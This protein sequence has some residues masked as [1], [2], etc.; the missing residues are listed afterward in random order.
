MPIKFFIFLFFL[1][2]FPKA[3]GKEKEDLV[4]SYHVG[5]GAA[6]Y[7]DLEDRGRAEVSIYVASVEKNNLDIEVYMVHQGVEL[8]EMWQFFELRLNDQKKIDLKRG[9]VWIKD[10]SS[11]E[12]IPDDVMKGDDDIL[13]SDFLITKEEDLVKYK[14]GKELLTIGKSKIETVHYQK[15]YSDKNIDFY[16]AS[17]VKPFGLVKLISKSTKNNPEKNYV[18]HLKNLIKGVKAKIDPTTAKPLSARVK[19]LLNL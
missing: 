6:Y 16:L 2:I 4:H 5:E 10:L 19:K 3:Y 8:T 13:L 1:I 15:K 14:V 12:I 11:P 18:M 9:L 7:L 17:K